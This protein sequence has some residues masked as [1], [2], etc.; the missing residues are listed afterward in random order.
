MPILIMCVDRDN[1]VGIKAGVSTPTIGREA[2]L[3]A[4]MQLAQV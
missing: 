3:E 4:A 1:D 2:C